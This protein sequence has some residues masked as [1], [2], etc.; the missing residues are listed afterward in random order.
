MDRKATEDAVKKE[1]T[2]SETARIDQLH[3]RHLQAEADLKKNQ[4]DM[5]ELLNRMDERMLMIEEQILD[6]RKHNE[7]QAEQRQRILGIF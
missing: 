5:E 3:E 7:Q 2:T 6:M 1:K 4:N